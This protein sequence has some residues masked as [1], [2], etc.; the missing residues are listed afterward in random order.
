MIWN[1][2][3]ET[4]PASPRAALQLERLQQTLEWVTA[5]V[6]FYAQRLG[7][8]RVR[9]LDDLAR[10]P[11]TRK[12]DLREHYP[13]GLFAVPPSEIVRIHASSGTKGKPTV[14]GY[15]AADLDV[16]CEV[17]ARAMVAA[18]ARPHDLLHIAFGYGLFT[19]GLGFHQGA[20]R[21]GMTVVPA[22]SGNTARHGLL[23]RDLGPAG[24]CGTPSFVLHIAETLAEQGTRP[25]GLGLRYG[26]FGAEPWTEGVRRA[27]ETALGCPAYDVYG[28]SE[29]VGPGVSGECEARDGL[30]LADDHFLPEIVD[31]ASGEPLGP[32]RQ[33]ELVLTTLTKR[34]MPIIRYRT[35]DITALTAEPC[36]CGRTSVRMAR[37]LG[38]ADDMLVI[39]GVNVY[40]SEV[41]EA[42]LGEDDL[43][44]HY[45]LVV[46][47]R[48]TLARVEVQVEPG[49][50][51]WERCGGPVAN[52][53]AVVAL[54]DRVTGRLRAALGL[55]V[56]VT[57]MPPRAIPRSEGKA[58]RV[59][60][61]TEGEQR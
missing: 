15:T 13:W 50:A 7:A 27:L 3:A 26:M 53:P 39:K 56:E 34:G 21:I 44:P 20:E 60:E 19:G 46:D 37:I 41:E 12:S 1:P 33:G 30:H 5:R 42:L 25:G 18:G 36:R 38:R 45:Q 43:L 58:V 57:L 61:R 52:H 48:E 4:Q 28:L 35:G 6:P 59:I 14:V 17:M 10:L 55:G 32:G 54:R 51:F 9:S 22:S 49:A 23:L 47:R 24:I 2:N 31:P 8:A 11:F 40:P 29:I 16:W